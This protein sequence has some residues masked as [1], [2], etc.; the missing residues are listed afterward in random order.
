MYVTL[1]VCVCACVRMYSKKNQS[2]GFGPLSETTGIGW[3]LL[4]WVSLFGGSYWY[5]HTHTHTHTHTLLCVCTHL[6]LALAFSLSL[7]LSLSLSSVA[8][9]GNG[10]QLN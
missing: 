9:N 5:T 3:T 10:I 6:A 8:L 2:T 7:S 1:N 4:L